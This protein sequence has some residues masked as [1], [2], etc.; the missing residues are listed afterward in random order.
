VN[1]YRII[2]L[3]ILA[4]SLYP[5][6]TT[7]QLFT[8]IATTVNLDVPGN[9]DGGVSW[10]DFNNDGCPDLILN[11]NDNVQ[12]S[13]LFMSDCNLPNPTFTDVTVT[14]CDG[15]LAQRMERSVI[16][17][18]INHDGNLDF[19]R[20]RSNRFEIYLNKGPTATPPYSFGDF[21]QNPNFVITNIPNGMNTEGF[22]WMDYDNDGWL[23]LIVENHN[24][25]ID[26]FKNPADGSANFFHVTPNG[27]TEGLPTGATTGDYMC[28]TDYNND[29]YVDILA[30]KEN[31]MDLWTN[32]GVPGPTRFAPNMSFNQQANNGNKGGVLMA[33][34]D[35]DGD[36]DIFWSDNGNNPNQIFL[37]TAPGVFAATGEPAASSGINLG[38]A[39]IDGCAAADINN[40]GKVDLFLA[41]GAGNGYLF[42]NNT[43]NGGALDFTRNNQGINI[44]GN[45]EGC[46]FVDFDRDGD[47]DLYINIRNGPNQ[48]WRNATNDLD[49][50]KVRA[51]QL[52]GLTATRDDVGA[53]VVL[54]DCNLNV[55]SGIRDV[56]GTRGHGSQD[57]AEIHFGLPNG[58]N[59]VYVVEVS[60]TRKSTARVV[61]QRAVIPST[62]PNQTLIMDQGGT[63]DLSLCAPL[64]AAEMMLEAAPA[65]EGVVLDWQWEVANAPVGFEVERSPD[66][67]TFE[68]IG[69]TDATTDHFL[70]AE[71]T[72]ERLFYRLRMTTDDGLHHL[73][74]VVEV[75]PQ[76]AP[77]LTTWPNPAPAGSAV[78]VEF[79]ATEA[80]EA[81]LQLFSL[82]GRRVHAETHPTTAG[83][84][85][86][87]LST[88]RLA[89]G[90][91]FLDLAAGTQ[92]FRTKITLA[93]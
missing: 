63:S 77:Q 68:K 16:W 49:Y 79:F 88:S 3:F 8:E 90:I 10:A 51:V 89:P 40:D 1:M 22:G 76:A 39:N 5:G 43:P 73:S 21:L 37:Q 14:H 74:P 20:N 62:L 78:H 33:D 91:Y 87:P 64:D 75:Q 72:G 83:R 56:N 57:P 31:E 52:V 58:P 81:R 41:D 85:Q 17:A 12:R 26:I 48:L 82:N 11:T 19:A 70:D 15:L 18:D 4:A 23:D 6:L 50:L 86:V 67:Q 9:K 35:N 61:L 71:A 38:G 27:N 13:R 69:A 65:A 25:G 36:F 45:A 29:G 84:N 32:S 93:Q 30:R 80:A 46:A 66:G 92:H 55:V 7:A 2:T 42:M 44:N 54:K 28:L 47:T 24:Y 60:F 53:T 59:A 34:F